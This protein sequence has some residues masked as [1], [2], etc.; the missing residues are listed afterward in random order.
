MPQGGQS[1]TH[2]L[3]KQTTMWKDS[4]LKG[5]YLRGCFLDPAAMKFFA[6]SFH[7]TSY[8]QLSKMVS[9]QSTRNTLQSQI[10]LQNQ[11]SSRSLWDD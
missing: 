11:N 2:D 10:R 6:S 9:M 8:E 7:V 3:S 5:A 1:L 4:L